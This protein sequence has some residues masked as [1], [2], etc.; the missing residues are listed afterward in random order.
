MNRR[1]GS[2]SMKWLFAL[3]VFFGILFLMDSCMQFRMNRSEIDSYFAHRKRKGE[4]HSYPVGSYRK[5]NYLKVGDQ[6]LP[7]V[8]FV[9]GSP[10]SLSAFIDFMADTL[11]L[12]R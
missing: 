2:K 10:G 4:L 3:F 7:L 1:R 8:I 12:R 6:N 9:H 11:L 5:I